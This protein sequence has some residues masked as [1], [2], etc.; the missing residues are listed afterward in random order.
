[1]AMASVG[2][3]QKSQRL[4]SGLR[5]CIDLTLIS[6]HPPAGLLQSICS[7]ISPVSWTRQVHF[8]PRDFHRP[9]CCLN[10]PPASTHLTD[11]SSLLQVFAQVKPNNFIHNFNHPDCNVTTILFAAAAVVASVAGF[12]CAILYPVPFFHR[13]FTLT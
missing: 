8:C 4:Y 11:S 6:H 10:A 7:D 3:S 12:T 2:P 1:M 13:L 5:V 9:S